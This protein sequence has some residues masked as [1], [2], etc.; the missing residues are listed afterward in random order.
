MMFCIAAVSAII[1]AA[2]LL[3]EIVV[4]IMGGSFIGLACFLCFFTLKEIFTS[5]HKNPLEDP[6]ADEIQ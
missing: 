3:D 5:R 2:S 4:V 6:P 1:L